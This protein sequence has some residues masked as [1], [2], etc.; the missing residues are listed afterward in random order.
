MGKLQSTSVDAGSVPSVALAYPSAVT[1]GSLLLCVVR[2][3]GG[4]T[5]PTSV[6]D[7][8]GQTLVLDKDQGQTTDNGSLSIWSFP[9]SASGA[10]TVTVTNGRTALTRV[11]I[12]EYS[13]MAQSRVLDQVNGGQADTVTS[14]TSGNVTTTQAN[15]L[16]MVASGTSTIMTMTAD[17]SFTA[18]EAIPA[19]PNTRL[20]TE[21]RI[22]SGIGTYSGAPLASAA[23]H[24]M[25]LIATYKY[26]GGGP[27]T[28][29]L[30]PR[31]AQCV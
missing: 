13:E 7:S 4:L 29:I 9:N 11:S 19:A 5:A 23:N 8:L 12:F 27:Y 25:T 22:L 30:G 20:F 24:M 28:V 16:L 3:G 17:G 2:L 6:V 1:A 10:D 15:E 14:I 18:Q 31:V 21:H 26:A